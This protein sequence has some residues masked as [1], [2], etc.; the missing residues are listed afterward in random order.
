MQKE[1]IIISKSKEK[2]NR[3]Q[4]LK[5]KTECIDLNNFL[6]SFLSLKLEEITIIYGW[7]VVIKKRRIYIVASST[8]VTWGVKQ[9]TTRTPYLKLDMIW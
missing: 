5:V 2:D 1:Q 3:E 4:S 6:L 8:I 7:E 9:G